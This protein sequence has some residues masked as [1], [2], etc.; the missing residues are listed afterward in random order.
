MVAGSGEE[1]EKE[2]DPKQEDEEPVKQEGKKRAPPTTT[3]KI[4]SFIISLLHLIP[5]HK[6]SLLT[7]MTTSSKP[8]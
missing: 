1:S 5:V 2:M 6:I 7:V 8:S 4:L 3:G